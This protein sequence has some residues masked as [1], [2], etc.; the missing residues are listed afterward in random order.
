MQKFIV[1]F[2]LLVLSFSVQAK[3]KVAP[4]EVQQVTSNIYALVG[5][6]TQRSPQ[7]FGNNATFGVIVTKAGVVLIDSGGSEKGAAQIAA[8]VK[9]VTSK[10]VIMVIN[11]GGQDHRWLGNHYF[12]QRGAKIIAS[13]AAVED[14]HQRANDQ[15]VMMEN[16]IGKKAYQGTKPVYAGQTFQQSLDLQVGG[17]QL[18]LRHA[19]QAHTPGDSYVW[20]PQSKVM[21]AGDIIFVERMLG[22][23]S[24]SNS[25]SWLK[26]FNAIAVHKPEKIIP[27]HGHVTDLA[28]ARRDTADYLR[29]LRRGVRKLMKAGGGLADVDNIDQSRFRYLKVYE[30]IKGRNASWVYQEMEW[31]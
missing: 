31:E 17:V 21:F 27:G 10:P 7:N 30:Q 3:D 5:E 13:A 15:Q 12:K 11:T 1:M 2:G 26:V 22:V 4:L 14:Q 9:T 23:S 20:L 28:T 18:Q 6:M 8:T 16:L 19:G 24:F 25:A 29:F